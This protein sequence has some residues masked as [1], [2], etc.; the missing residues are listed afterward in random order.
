MAGPFAQDLV[1]A[2][3][4]LAFDDARR[5]WIPFVSGVSGSGSDLSVPETISIRS[6]GARID[7]GRAR[8]A[9][10]GGTAQWNALVAF[11]MDAAAVLEHAAA[12]LVD[13]AGGS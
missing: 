4:A 10:G 6:P 1:S 13:L 12:N 5:L 7:Y 8:A 3:S 2:G 9:G 11:R